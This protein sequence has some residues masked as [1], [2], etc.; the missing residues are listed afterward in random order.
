MA[1]FTKGIVSRRE[2]PVHVTHVSFNGKRNRQR[3]THSA[4]KRANTKPEQPNGGAST[5][6]IDGGTANCCTGRS[7]PVDVGPGKLPKTKH[8]MEQNSTNANHQSTQRLMATSLLIMAQSMSMSMSM[9]NLT[10]YQLLLLLL[11]TLERAS[12]PNG[13]KRPYPN[14]IQGLGNLPTLPIVHSNVMKTHYSFHHAPTLHFPDAASI[15][16]IRKPC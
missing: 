3:Q 11:L 16:G 10:I 15:R 5:G 7:T 12:W 1:S 4:T 9:L 2:R 8:T 6:S 13:P 14:A